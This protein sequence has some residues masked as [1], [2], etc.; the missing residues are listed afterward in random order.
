MQVKVKPVR[1]FARLRQGKVPLK[2]KEQAGW[3]TDQQ[4]RPNGAQAVFSAAAKIGIQD[5]I[6]DAAAS[7]FQ[8]VRGGLEPMEEDSGRE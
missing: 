1:P 8:A 2:E 4:G 6:L 7:R 3:R 5:R